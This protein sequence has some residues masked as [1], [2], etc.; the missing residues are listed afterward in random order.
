MQYKKYVKSDGNTVKLFKIVW[1]PFCGT[2]DDP[3][4][5]SDVCLGFQ[6]ILR[7]RTLSSACET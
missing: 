6:R 7:L 1:S 4:T 3:W 5:C 2:T